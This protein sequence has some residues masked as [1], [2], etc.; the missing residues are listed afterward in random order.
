MLSRCVFPDGVNRIAL[1]TMIK[2]FQPA[3]ALKTVLKDMLARKI[4]ANLSA[5]KDSSS[6]IYLITANAVKRSV[7]KEQYVLTA[8]AMHTTR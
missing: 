7:R 6:L 3:S 1:L 2:T 8:N 5:R 4:R